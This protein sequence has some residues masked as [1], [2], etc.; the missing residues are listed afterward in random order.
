M[1]FALLFGV[2]TRVKDPH[3]PIIDPGNLVSRILNETAARFRP[4][5]SR[6]KRRCCAPITLLTASS[7]ALPLKIRNVSLEEDTTS[8]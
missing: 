5:T 4:R 6:I 3:R 7:Q 2:L 1:Q 8:L